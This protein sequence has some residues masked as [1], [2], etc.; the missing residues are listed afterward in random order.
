MICREYLDNFLVFFLAGKLYF[1]YFRLSIPI[2]ESFLLIL[3]S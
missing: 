3:S 2:V 1:S